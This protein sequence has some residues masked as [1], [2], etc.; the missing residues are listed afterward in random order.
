MKKAE[1]IML[2]IGYTFLIGMII[3]MFVLL[4]MVTIYLIKL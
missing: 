4:T 1:K 2:I 3:E